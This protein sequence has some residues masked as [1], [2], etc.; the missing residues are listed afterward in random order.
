MN[1]DSVGKIAPLI[2]ADVYVETSEQEAVTEARPAHIEPCIRNG[3]AITNT[4]IKSKILLA[5]VKIK[6]VVERSFESS[7]L[8]GDIEMTDKLNEH[9]TRASSHR[10]FSSNPK[11]YTVKFVTLDP[12]CPCFQKSCRS[13]TFHNPDKCAC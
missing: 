10:L 5:L 6:S 7:T 1:A 4:A 3:K 9:K 8:S 12:R 2:L 13:A 11:P